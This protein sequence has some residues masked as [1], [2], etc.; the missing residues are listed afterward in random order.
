MLLRKRGPKAFYEFYKS[1]L[2]TDN[3]VIAELLEPGLTRDQITAVP[4]QAS[5]MQ[6]PTSET[7][8][9]QIHRQESS[10]VD[11]DMPSG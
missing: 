5:S 10:K 7:L 11:L 4:R 3:D 2:L 1:L 8:H 6:H 9:K